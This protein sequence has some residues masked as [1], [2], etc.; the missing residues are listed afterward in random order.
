[1][2]KTHKT[3]F[4]KAVLD[5][6]VRKFNINGYSENYSILRQEKIPRVRTRPFSFIPRESKFSF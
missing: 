2:N 1:M 3:G 4:F 5:L 6:R